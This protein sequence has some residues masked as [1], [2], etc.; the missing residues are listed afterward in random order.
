MKL[1]LLLVSWVAC[2]VSMIEAHTVL[3]PPYGKECFF[4]NLRKNDELSVSFQVGSRDPLNAE[5]YV[6]DFV[7]CKFD[8]FC[9][10]S[11]CW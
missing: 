8:R 3:I 7:V 9:L 2:L 5:Q 1:A 10:S 4:E 11:T 6:I